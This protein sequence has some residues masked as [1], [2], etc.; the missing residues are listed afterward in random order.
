MIFS[1][2]KFLFFLAIVVLI[3]YIVPKKYRWTVLLLGSMYFYYCSKAVFIPFVGGVSVFSYLT[4][5]IISLKY[6]KIDLESFNLEKDEAKE[7]RAKGSAFCKRILILALIIILGLLVYTKIAKY[8]VNSFAHIEGF[9]VIVPLGISYFTFSTVGYM[10]DVYWKRYK[11]EKNFFKYLLYVIYFPHITQGPIPRYDKLSESLFAE[12]AFS[13]EKICEGCSRILWGFFKK[14]IIADVAGIVVESVFGSWETQNYITIL[15]GTFMYA[16]QVYVDFAAC[17][18]MALGISHM[19]GVD[20]EEN[21]RQPYFSRS[22][23]EFWRRWHITLGKWFK[24]YLCM[25]VSV[26]K[27]VKNLSKKMRKKYGNTAGKNTVTI[28]AL[29]AVWICTGLWHGTGLNY[30]L[31]GCW[32]GGIIIFSTLMEKNYSKAKKFLRINEDAIWWKGFQMIRTFI[33]CGIIP[34]LLTRA[35]SVSV[36]VILFGRVLTLHGSSETVVGILN[37]SGVNCGRLIAMLIGILALFT[38]SVLKE[39]K[40]WDGLIRRCPFII[41]NVV[42]VILIYTIIMFA[43]GDSDITSG[44]MYANF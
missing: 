24:D 12:H 36:A 35:A 15:F 43:G 22:V 13:Y 38:V 33:L 41:R 29:I 39:I 25:P 7:L 34:R 14:Q 19:F 8:V 21:F 37:N 11:A 20:L 27:P 40:I 16:I 17:M 44:F 18:D 28:S 42:Y 30:V 23:E 4:A 3:Y 31:W 26:C 5:R 1:S 32:Q 6:E 10:L 9:N 2:F